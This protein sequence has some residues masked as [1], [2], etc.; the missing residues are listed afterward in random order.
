[1]KTKVCAKC[2]IKKNISEFYRKPSSSNYKS[3]CRECQT[4]Y[5]TE[6][7]K[8]H[9]IKSKR[10]AKKFYYKNRKKLLLINKIW[11]EEHKKER[12]AY[13]KE[14]VRLNRKRILKSKRNG[15]C[16]KA[17]GITLRQKKEMILN[18]NNKCLSCGTDLRKLKSKN[19]CIDHDHKSKQIRGILCHHCNVVLGLM[20]EDYDKILKLAK[21]CK[22]YCKND[23]D[24]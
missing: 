22:K 11:R 20:K 24:L 12:A 14:Y 9:P 18:Q 8:K 3:Q 1:M 6:Y 5:S 23:N 7:R 21:Y 19:I 15:A 2:K 10:K 4:K 16:K 13:N 17:Y